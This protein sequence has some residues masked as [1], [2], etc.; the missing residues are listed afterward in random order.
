MFSSPWFGYLIILDY[1]KLIEDHNF[2]QQNKLKGEHGDPGVKGEKGE[3]G[4]G[5]YDPR[6]GG[7]LGPPGPPGNPGLPVSSERAAHIQTEKLRG[8]FSV[9]DRIPV[10]V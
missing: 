4:G 5:Y 1:S 2:L 3:P 6:F 9:I 10:K 7:P 8:C